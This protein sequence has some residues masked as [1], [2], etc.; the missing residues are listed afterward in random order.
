[1]HGEGFKCKKKDPR[2][3]NYDETE[4]PLP[5]QRPDNYVK[6]QKKRSRSSDSESTQMSVDDNERA[7]IKADIKE[8]KGLMKLIL[9]KALALPDGVRGFF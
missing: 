5:K 9:K 4:H 7:A 8:I 2:D 3:P 6:R 1:V